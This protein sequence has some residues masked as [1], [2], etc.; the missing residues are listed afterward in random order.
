MEGVMAVYKKKKSLHVKPPP[1]LLPTAL[2]VQ[3]HAMKPG[4]NI[5]SLI[6]SRILNQ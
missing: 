5:I 6:L 3:S 2:Y 4:Q 1:P